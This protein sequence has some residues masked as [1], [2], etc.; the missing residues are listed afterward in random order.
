MKIDFSHAAFV[1]S[2]A[3]ERGFP[4][5]GRP[6]VVF[7]GRSNVGKSSVINSILGKK[8][9]RVS[10]TPGKTLFVNLYLVDERLWFVDL[11]GY[12]YAH[13]SKTERER[14]SKLID[15]YLASDL[16]EIRLMVLLVDARHKPT[17]DDKIMLSWMQETKVPIVVVANKLDKLKPRE[18]EESLSVIREA[19]LLESNVKLIGF[20]SET[21][22]NKEDVLSAIRQAAGDYGT[23]LQ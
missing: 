7:V 11:P 1:R 8:F 5:D 15:S 9:A 16:P 3:D 21:E 19:L 17:E 23:D 18:W 6:R 22:I 13:V 2:A 14:F 12:G 20:S 10:A 4:R